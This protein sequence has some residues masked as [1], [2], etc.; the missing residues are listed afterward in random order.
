MYSFLSSLILTTIL[1]A[2]VIAEAYCPRQEDSDFSGVIT[3]INVTDDSFLGFV[4]SN[5]GLWGSFGLTNET[6]E[7]MKF[8][9]WDNCV[10]D[11]PVFLS[12]ENPINPM[13]S[14][15]SVVEDLLTDCSQA[16]LPGY[17]F[18]APSNGKPQG[19]TPPG[20]TSCTMVT[21]WAGDLVGLIPGQED[22]SILSTHL[23][24]SYR[25]DQKMIL[26]IVEPAMIYD[27]DENAIIFADPVT[28]YPWSSRSTPIR[29]LFW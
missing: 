19:T 20:P 1:I 21:L 28:A 15:A 5:L 9:Y 24:F 13:F 11:E 14:Y 7:L 8:K 2:P 16:K 12:I 25:A 26:A 4:T 23:T 29:L 27:P 10:A 17:L 22:V 6:K 18:F 3:A